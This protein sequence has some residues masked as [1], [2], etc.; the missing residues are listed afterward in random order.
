MFNRWFYF[1][2]TSFFLVDWYEVS[3]RNSL[4]KIHLSAVKMQW[5]FMNFAEHPLHP[6]V[7]L[8]VWEI[9][10][11]FNIVTP[12]MFNSSRVNC[13][14]RTLLN[15]FQITNYPHFHI[16]LESLPSIKTYC[17][18]YANFF[19]YNL[20][21]YFRIEYL[22]IVKLAMNDKQNTEQKSL[23]SRHWNNLTR[24]EINRYIRIY[25]HFSTNKTKCHK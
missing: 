16:E 11:S 23:E 7:K 10:C 20:N 21:R 13:T 25:N 22:I 12:T 15:I 19:H 18:V 6:L 3:K 14:W 1:S 5:R 9:V 2:F 8:F 4:T 17:L 24:S